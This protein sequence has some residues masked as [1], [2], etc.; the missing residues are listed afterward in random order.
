MKGPFLR[1]QVLKAR[2]EET[3]R[4]KLVVPLWEQICRH[5]F[6]FVC[7]PTFFMLLNNSSPSSSCLFIWFHLMLRGPGM[8]QRRRLAKNLRQ[9]RESFSF[10]A[11]VELGIFICSFLLKGRGEARRLHEVKDAKYFAVETLWKINV[12][13]LWLRTNYEK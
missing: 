6:S 11:V 13:S 10:I 8:Q 12:K 3:I 5:K 1:R 7:M 4:R 2:T 9:E